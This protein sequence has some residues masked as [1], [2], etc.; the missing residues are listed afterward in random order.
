MKGLGSLSAW[1]ILGTAIMGCQVAGS[2]PLER[3]QGILALQDNTFRPLAGRSNAIVLDE[4]TAVFLSPETGDHRL[5]RPEWSRV[6]TQTLI[7]SVYPDHVEHGGYAVV[8]CL[9]AS[10]RSLR[11]CQMRVVEPAGLGFE[12]A[13]S[14]LIRQYRLGG[15]AP[16]S[17]SI[18]VVR[19]YL[20]LRN[21]SQPLCRPPFCH[22][23]NFS[24][25]PPPPPPH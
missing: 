2:R 14:R 21:N 12:T 8:E 25:P 23:D 7:Q 1:S 18:G 11:N 10:N 9:A 24:P 22:I 13:F 6:P 15:A 3:T 19:L 4:S 17:H 5:H 16:P 20:R